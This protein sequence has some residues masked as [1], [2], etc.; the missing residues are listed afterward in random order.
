MKKKIIPAII[1]V[2]CFLTYVLPFIMC[3]SYTLKR[4]IL[5]LLSVCC[6]VSGSWNIYEW[7]EKKE[8]KYIK[9]AVIDFSFSILGVLYLSNFYSIRGLLKTRGVYIP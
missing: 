9:Y 1:K 2:I 5:A 4:G 6:L 8:T 7:R 3:N